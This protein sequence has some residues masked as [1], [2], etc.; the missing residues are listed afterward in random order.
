MTLT[1]GRMPANDSGASCR[2]E[3]AL[4]GS[5]QTAVA[6]AVFLL[7]AGLAHFAFPR[8][9]RRIV[10]RILKHPAF[11]VALSGGA[12]IGCAALVAYP[13]TRPVGASLA[14]VLFVAVF[15]ANVQVALDRGI[16]GEPFPW[17]SPAIAWLRLP[18]QIPL[19][20][21][22]QRIAGDAGDG[23]RR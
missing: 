1:R 19:I 22:A 17:G 12:E 6:L 11:W 7:T 10:P 5:S 15:P 18:L 2:P 13:R 21:W 16:P 9:Y 23:V 14:I 3:S 4:R 8:P 20:L